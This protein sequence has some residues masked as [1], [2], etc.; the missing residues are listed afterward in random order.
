MQLKEIIKEQLSFRHSTASSSH[1]ALVRLDDNE[2]GSVLSCWNC[3]TQ[4]AVGREH[5]V[6]AVEHDLEFDGDILVSRFGI[7]VR[8]PDVPFATKDHRRKKPTS[9]SPVSFRRGAEFVASGH[10]PD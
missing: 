10:I 7:E 8:G 6:R 3:D 4:M 5:L 1:L 2:A 9:P